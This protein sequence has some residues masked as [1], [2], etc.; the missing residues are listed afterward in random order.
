MPVVKKLLTF[1]KKGLLMLSGTMFFVNEKTFFSSKS[2]SKLYCLGEK[3]AAYV[4]FFKFED[5]NL[6]YLFYLI[7]KHPAVV[8]T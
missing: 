8:G 3:Y 6:S 2:S 1:L 5:G 7:W 4:N